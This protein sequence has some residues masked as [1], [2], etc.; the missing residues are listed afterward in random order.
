MTKDSGISTVEVV[1]VFPVF[2]FVILLVIQFALWEQ[3]NHIVQAA[4]QHGEQIAESYGSNPSAGADAARQF[5]QSNAGGLIINPSISSQVEAGNQQ[6]VS[7]SGQAESII[8][9]FTLSVE[10]SSI[11]PVQ[12]FRPSG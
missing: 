2:M 8:P 11:G 9:L 6:V 4:A 12:M 10:A 3:A 5:L 7:I 1:L